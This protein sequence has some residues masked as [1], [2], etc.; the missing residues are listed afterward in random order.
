MIIPSSAHAAFWKASDYFGVRLHVIPVDKKSRRANVSAMRRAVNPNTIL[1]VGSAP[2]FPDGAIDPIPD[3]ARIARKHKIGLHVDC[4]LGSLLMP[5]LRKTG[6]GEG[7]VGGF[8]FEVDGVTSISCDVHKYGF[9]PKGSSII[10]YRDAELR[11]YQYYIQPDWAG[12]VYASPSMA[13]SR[14]GSIIAGAWAVMTHMGM[15]GYTQSCATILKATRKL[16]QAIQ[17]DRFSELYVL[18]DPMVSVVA[19]SVDEKCGLKENDIYAVGDLMSKKGWHLSALSGPPALHLAMTMLTAK[20]VDTLLDDLRA[21]IDEIKA[22]PP[23][24]GDLVALYGLGQTSVGPLLVP[25][26][27]EMFIDTMF[28]TR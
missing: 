19:F 6:Y 5:F 26:L 2:N 15:D 18:G 27:A 8:G 17:S 28:M 23:D 14:P 16:K 20:A 4:C 11:R 1:L 22:S 3:L 13:G 25:K 21:A 24:S 10:M 9:C 12:G 7:V